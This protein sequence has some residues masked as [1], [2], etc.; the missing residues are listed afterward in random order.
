MGSHETA[1]VGAVRG[2]RWARRPEP[3]ARRPELDEAGRSQARG[4]ARQQEAEVG[5]ARRSA[6]RAREGDGGRDEGAFRRG[7][8]ADAQVGLTRGNFPYELSQA[9]LRNSSGHG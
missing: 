1:A 5:G 2:R 9:E 4:G 7:W 3:G 6:E 8:A